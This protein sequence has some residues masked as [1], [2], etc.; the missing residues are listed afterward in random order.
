MNILEYRHDPQL[1][2][3]LPHMR[4]PETQERWDV[5]LA[6]VYGLPLSD[7]ALAL[8][9]R[10]T[11]RQTPRPCGYPEAVVITGRQSGKTQTA[12]DIV[13]FDA[14]RS[15]VQREVS[16]R[17]T[18]ALLVA[19]DQRGAMRTLFRTIDQHFEEIPLLRP[20][21]TRRTNDTI[22]LD[23]GLEIAA[24][25]CRPAALRG[26]RARV[27]VVDELAHF[28]STDNIPTDQETLRTVRPCLSTTG[29]KLIV[30]SSPFGQSGALWE[31]HRRS[32]GNEDSPTLIWQASAP[33]MNALL[34]ADYISRMQ[35]DDPDAFKSEVLGEFRAGVSSLFDP[36]TI[37][38]SIARGC[39]ELLPEPKIS[40]VAGADW[41]GG[42]HDAACLSIGHE[43][44]NLFIQ[45]CL[46][47]WKAPFDPLQAVSE[48]AALLRSY[49]IGRVVGDRYSAEF[50]VGAFRQH[51]IA[52]AASDLDR[53]ALYLEMLAPLNAGKIRLLDE[54][55]LHRE[56]RGLCRTRMSSGRER[57]DHIRGQ[58]DDRANSLAMM[59]RQLAKKSA[60][61]AL[62]I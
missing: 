37:D 62:G 31:L 14:A 55:S 29:G 49:R 26:L 54:P 44:G 6:A 15:L 41:S 39:R 13:A 24:Y 32:W 33:E 30:L 38:A 47:V 61:G 43:S 34:P 52:Y 11:G 45:D 10:H 4:K 58:H 40:Y 2:G 56:L 12:A 3:L 5:F 21:V 46:R 42:R 36:D 57:V 23:S 1:G 7:A 53:S 27:V 17:G 19:Q 51:S 60:A 35:Q 18:H 50:I 16:A 25:P 8:F 20:H 59:I 22:S 9:R 28:R 48:A